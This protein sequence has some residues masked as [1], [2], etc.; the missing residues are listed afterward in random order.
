VPPASKTKVELVPASVT[1]SKLIPPER[2]K[3][4]VS[5]RAGVPATQAERREAA[6]SEM[7][8]EQL[9]IARHHVARYQIHIT[10][11]TARLLTDIYDVTA[12]TL[13][14]LKSDSSRESVRMALGQL[15]DYCRFVESDAHPGPPRLVIALPMPPDEDL[16]D[17]LAAHGV[18]LTYP[19]DGTFVGL[20]M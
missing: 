18:L 13:Y 9:K 12:H 16:R 3:K 8:E 7:L 6:L 10:G 11:K 15:L 17:L 2:G 20:P 5:A 4:P 14:E 19:V 1:S